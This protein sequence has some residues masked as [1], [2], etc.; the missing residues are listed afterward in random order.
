MELIQFNELEDKIKNIVQEYA[1]L[2]KKNQELEA[3]LKNK[4]EELEEVSKKIE[5]L[6]EERDAVRAKVDRLLVLLQDVNM[7]Q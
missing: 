7:S 2:K 5:G 4:T 3:L 1:G 6:I